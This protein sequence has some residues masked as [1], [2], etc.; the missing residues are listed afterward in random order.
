MATY[1]AT[2][3][4]IR[5]RT[6]LTLLAGAT[7]ASAAALWLLRPGPPRLGLLVALAVASGV[8]GAGTS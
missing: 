3:D 7:G 5:P 4:R 6:A 2:F 1:P 8:G